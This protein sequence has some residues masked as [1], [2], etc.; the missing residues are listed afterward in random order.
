MLS[1]RSIRFWQLD[2][3]NFSSPVKYPIDEGNSLIQVPDINNICKLSIPGRILG[4]LTSLEQSRRSKYRRDFS[5]RLLG[6]IWSFSQP[7]SCKYSSLSRNPTD[8]W[9]STKFLH[10]ERSKCTK[11]GVFKAEKFTMASQDSHW[12]YFKFSNLK[13]WIRKQNSNFISEKL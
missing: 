3:S 13:V 9:T 6:R 5:L 10:L 8:S 12:I 11:F 7:L 4:N 2:T 1:G